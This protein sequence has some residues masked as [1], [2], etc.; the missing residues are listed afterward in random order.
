MHIHHTHT[1]ALTY[2][3]TCTPAN[4]HAHAHIVLAVVDAVAAIVILDTHI[5]QPYQHSRTH[6]LFSF[7]IFGIRKVI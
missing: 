7:R 5:T 6:T 1:H 3:K 4:I 2:T